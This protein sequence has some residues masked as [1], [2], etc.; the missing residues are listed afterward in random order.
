MPLEPH[1]QRIPLTGIHI[2]RGEPDEMCY[3]PLALALKDRFRNRIIEVSRLC[4]KMKEVRGGTTHL[5]MYNHTQEVIEWLDNF[6]GGIAVMP[7]T[8]LIQ[9][10]KSKLSFVEVKYDI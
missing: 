5:F 10:W 2:R 4:T 7:Q 9:H 8:I 6:D 3:C 1:E